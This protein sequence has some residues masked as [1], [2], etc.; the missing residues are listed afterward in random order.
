MIEKL[1]LEGLRYAQAVAETK[2]FSAA[3]R[4]YGVTQPALSNGIAKLED[5]LGGKLFDRSP[6]G[7]TPTAFGARILPL[8]DH[9]LGALGSVA[10]E[11]QRLTEPGE[12]K[13]RMGV[14]PLSSHL[15][16]RMFGVLRGLPEP[17]D[18]VV[19]GALIPDLQQGLASGELDVV[20]MP[21][22]AA[23]PGFE[24]R[25]V[26][27]DPIVVVGCGADAPIEIDEASKVQFLLVPDPCGLTMF[28]KRLFRSHGLPLRAYPGEAASYRVL[29]QWTAL[30]LGAALIPRSKLSSPGVPH[31]PLMDEGH[32]VRISFEA[33]W[34]VDSAFGTDLAWLTGELAG[35]K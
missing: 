10:A 26:D 27:V 23:M 6:R 3:A 7:V 34:S 32:E 17:R 9:A 4:A 25:V 35:D 15:V 24:H 21:S 18:L 22:V 20:L 2:S 12:S 28:T 33:L 5:R 30:G 19:R 14:S 13:I 11:A 29:E 1:N 8:I 31:R 16:A